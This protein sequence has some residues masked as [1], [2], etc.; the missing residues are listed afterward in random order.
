LIWPITECIFRKICEQ[1]LVWK[2][3][4]LDPVTMRIHIPSVLLQKKN[5]PQMLNAVL[6]ELGVTANVLEL[7]VSLSVLRLN[8]DETK[9]VLNSLDIMGIKLLL[10]DFG[11]HRTSLYIIA[12]Y[13][14]S[15]III[16]KQL[17][18]QATDQ[19]NARKLIKTILGLCQ[20]MKLSVTASGID[21]PEQN[22]LINK[23]HCDQAQGKLYGKSVN[24][25]QFSELMRLDLPENII[26]IENTI[27]PGQQAFITQYIDSLNFLP[28]MPDSLKQ[29]LRLRNHVDLKVHDLC[30]VLIRDPAITAQLI[31]YANAPFFGNQ[32]RIKTLDQAVMTALGLEGALN[33]AMGIALMGQVQ[34]YSKDYIDLLAFWQHAIFSA[35]LSQSIASLLPAT[36]VTPGTAF[37]SGLLQNIGYL[38]LCKDFSSQIKQARQ[39]LRYNPEL[40]ITEVEKQIIGTNHVEVG[41]YLLRNWQLPEEIVTAVFEHHN[42]SYIGP[43]AIYPN[44][45]LIANRLLAPAHLTDETVSYIP[46]AMLQ[47][48]TLQETQ[49]MDMLEKV[50]HQ[51]DRLDTL[52]RHLAA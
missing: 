42:I 30:M 27:K 51:R 44:I 20:S 17:V 46:P 19:I 26:R 34:A 12:R 24:A 18:A 2:T 10:D 35:T 47:I 29:L 39:E 33:M 32:G 14:I 9:S 7:T 3:Q 13:P 41:L 4:G 52:S 23:W 21:T 28:P 31:R 16:N 48:H 36:T 40:V 50:M 5:F 37:L 15:G 49:L 38:V 45:I 6:E 25:E 22:T 8:S 1:Y 11:N 43:Y